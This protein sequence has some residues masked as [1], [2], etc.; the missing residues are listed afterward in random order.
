V[1]KKNPEL[2]AETVKEITK[3]WRWTKNKY[4]K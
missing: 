2:Y 3:K 1:R 4:K